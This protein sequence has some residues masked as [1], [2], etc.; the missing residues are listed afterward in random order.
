MDLDVDG[1]GF[2]L[3]NLKTKVEGE[4]FSFHYNDYTY[5]D[6]V[7]TGELGKKIFNGDLKSN[8]PNAKLSFNGLADLSQEI[9]SFDFKANVEYAN[10]NTLNFVSRDKVS[11]FK[12]K[13]NME[14]KGSNYDNAVGKVLI[15][16]TTYK[17]QDGQ[18]K[19]QDF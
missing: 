15:K 11:E 4:V 9:K 7:V 16:N 1:K 8:D 12:G 14:V 17:N 18:Y 6:I 3:E 19:F 2:T 13:V 10:L 5:K